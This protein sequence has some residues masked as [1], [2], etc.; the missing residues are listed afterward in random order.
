MALLKGRK[1]KTLQVVP[2][3]PH[4]PTIA[5]IKMEMIAE[6]LLLLCEPFI[7]PYKPL[8]A[9]FG[10]PLSAQSLLPTSSHQQSNFNT[11]DFLNSLNEIL[12]AAADDQV[13]LEHFEGVLLEHSQKLQELFK[14]ATQ[15]QT[16]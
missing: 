8:L 7:R 11:R 1:K 12:Q 15:E 6:V 9:A 2:S 10:I 4:E 14:A 3:E 5:D 16:A 13:A